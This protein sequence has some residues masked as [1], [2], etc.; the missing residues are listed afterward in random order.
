MHIHDRDRPEHGKETACRGRRW[1]TK[2]ENENDERFPALF[3]AVC[4]AAS[5]FPRDARPS[6]PLLF[7]R[8]GRRHH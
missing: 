2:V 4:S 1:T 7:H 8:R 3:R 5:F 6:Q